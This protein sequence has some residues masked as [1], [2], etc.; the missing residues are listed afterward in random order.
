MLND[1]LMVMR[2]YGI[3]EGEFLDVQFMRSSRL[4][5][6]LERII[7]P[8]GTYPIIGRSLAYRC[9]VFHL[10]SQAVLLKILPKNIKPSQVRS[11]LT[12]VLKKQFEDDKNFNNEGWLVL[13]FNGSQPDMCEKE[14]N[15]GSLYAC[16][17]IFLPLGL[18]SDDEFKNL[19]YDLILE[20]VKNP[21]IFDTKNIIKEVP[22]EIKLYNYGN[23]YEL[24]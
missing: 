20:N 7:S 1:I 18:N 21:V 12:A 5:S 9:G 19:N 6:Q 17:E 22:G 15:T 2:K 23:L 24:S 8:E 16:C 4:S 11:A 10:L 13:G 3:S 14:V